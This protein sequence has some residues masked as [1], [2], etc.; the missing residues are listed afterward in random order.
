MKQGIREIKPTAG[1]WNYKKDGFRI[2]I[3]NEKRDLKNPVKNHDY[4][5]CEIDDNSLQ[6]EANAKLI[7]AAPDLL[8][9]LNYSVALICEFGYKNGSVCQ[10]ALKAIKKATE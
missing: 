6:A 4:T 7:C 5:V 8:E 10:N 9:A 3:G 1:N 2:T